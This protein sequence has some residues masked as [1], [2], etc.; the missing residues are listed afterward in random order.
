MNIYI[1]LLQAIANGDVGSF[2]IRHNFNEP[3]LDMSE[4]EYIKEICNWVIQ[5]RK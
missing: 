3:K 1:E 4:S 5:S 2:A